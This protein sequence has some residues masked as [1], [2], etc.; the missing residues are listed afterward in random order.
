MP[1][2]AMREDDEARLEDEKQ[3]ILAL[4]GATPDGR[5]ELIGLTVCAGGLLPWQV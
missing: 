1:W 3:C 2:L 4:I 5:K